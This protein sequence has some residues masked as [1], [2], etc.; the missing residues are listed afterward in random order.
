MFDDEETEIENVE[1]ENES[2]E[3]PYMKTELDKSQDK[4]SGDS[5]DDFEDLDKKL[6]DGLLSKE[7]LSISLPDGFNLSLGS[8]KFNVKELSEL[9]IDIRNKLYPNKINKKEVKYT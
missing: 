7:H 5:D 8:S 1:I 6:D 4:P 3:M 9:M 2:P